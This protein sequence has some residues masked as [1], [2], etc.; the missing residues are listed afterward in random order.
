M[1]GPTA[2]ANSGDDDGVV[3]FVAIVQ[4]NR[5]GEC[6]SGDNVW[7]HR[8]AL[9]ELGGGGFFETNDAAAS[10]QKIRIDDYV[11]VPA[12]SCDGSMTTI[13]VYCHEFGHAFGLPD[14]YD[15]D[16]SNGK[17]AGV[18]WWDLMGSGSMGGDGKSL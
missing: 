18:G 13:G 5:G 9:T 11:V 12:L 4:P 1:T 8:F 2:I 7:S 14:L 17:S 10:G 15:T 16:E 3:D 6:K